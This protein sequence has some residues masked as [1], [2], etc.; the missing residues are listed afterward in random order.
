MKHK[1][2]AHS[3]F[4]ASGAERWMSCSGS[5]ALSEG[6]PDK[7]SDAA[8]EGTHAHEVL[9]QMLLN[10]N[11]IISAPG[12]MIDHGLAA[13]EFMWAKQ[14][15]HE[16]SDLI[17]ENRVYLDFIHPEMFGTYDGAVVDYFGTLH[18]FDY[19]YGKGHMVTPKNNWQMLFYGMGLAHKFHW[20]FKTV[21]LWII[22]PRIRGYD[23][24]LF[25]EIPISEL[26]RYVP[27]FRQAVERVLTR[28]KS[29]KEGSWCWF[30]KAKNICPLK[31]EKRLQDAKSVFT[32]INS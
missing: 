31:K 12:E 3:K 7:T 29:Y 24:P 30:C 2:R 5:V 9:E 10:A 23:G 25:W 18:V 32:K 21:K 15:E 8:L 11:A 14:K 28:P 4:S 27:K 20:N 17:V 6:L 26:R 22:Q 13:A 19:K 16:G 1:E